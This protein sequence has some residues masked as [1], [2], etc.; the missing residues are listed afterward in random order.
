MHGSGW[1][2]GS[3]SGSGSGGGG[4]GA[5][6]VWSRCVNVIRKSVFEKGN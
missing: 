6:C 2:S 3:G 5:G 4:G 1:G